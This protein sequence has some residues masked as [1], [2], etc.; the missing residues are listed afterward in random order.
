MSLSLGSCA[1]QRSRVSTILRS[2]IIFAS[3]LVTLISSNHQRNR[4][5]ERLLLNYMP[6]KCESP[7]AMLDYD[8]MV[9]ILL[10]QGK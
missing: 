9:D 4:L 2:L 3:V 8:A 7:T 1:L 6:C 10:K 5:L